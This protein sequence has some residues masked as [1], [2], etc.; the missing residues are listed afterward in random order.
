[1]KQKSILMSGEKSING[2]IYSG[3]KAIP[4]INEI[5]LAIDWTFTKTSLDLFQWAKFESVYD[6]IYITL[7]SMTAKKIRP[8][9][10]QMTKFEKILLG[11]IVWIILLIVLVGPMLL[12][13]D[14]NPMK[15]LNNVDGAS[16]SIKFSIVSDVMNNFTLFENKQ[17]S[18]IKEMNDEIWSDFDYGGNLK[19]KK[20]PKKQIQIIYMYENSDTI[21]SLAKPYI[22]TIIDTLNCTKN[23]TIHSLLS[24]IKQ[25]NLYFEYSFSRPF[26]TATQTAT[27][28]LDYNLF[29]AGDDKDNDIIKLKIVNSLYDALT[30]KQTTTEINLDDFY[31]P[32][33]KLNADNKPKLIK[34][35]DGKLENLI[36]CNFTFNNCFNKSNESVV[37]Y[38]SS[39]FSL[40]VADEKLKSG[41]IQFHT[42]SEKV[43]TYTSS[44]NVVTFYVTFILLIGGY[45][46]QFLSGN[47]EKIQLTEMPEPKPLINLCAGIKIARYSFELK[48]EENLYYILIEFMRSPEY[49][50]MITKSSLDAFKKRKEI[51][52]DDEFDL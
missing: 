39:Y 31:I 33:I 52:E 41:G 16:I 6:T 44:Y 37:D 13:S 2:G 7:C 20:F 38:S 35:N 15:E 17:V 36:D 14:L 32:S 43:S 42:F 4:F 1:M 19:I 46:K 40:Y 9:G 21:F 22:Q 48:K 49:L 34:G 24:N 28:H 23:G 27:K 30:C 12:F 10:K 5:K 25:I 3:F 47:P 50:K 45:V 11:W 18:D 29:K 8:I 51:K 26:P